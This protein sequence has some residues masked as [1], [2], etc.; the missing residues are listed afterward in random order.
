MHRELDGRAVS[1]VFAFALFCSQLCRAGEPKFYDLNGLPE[2]VVTGVAWW[3]G[4]PPPQTS[5]TWK[6][7][8]DRKEQV[9]GTKPN[10]PIDCNNRTPQ[11]D[12]EHRLSD[13]ENLLNKYKVWLDGKN[14]YENELVLQ[15]RSDYDSAVQN[16]D[17][18]AETNASDA[19][20]RAEQSRDNIRQGKEETDRRFQALEKKREEQ[21][22]E[23]QRACG[24]KPPDKRPNDPNKQPPCKQG[25]GWLCM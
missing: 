1:I 13:M 6:G 11:G 21:E 20:K 19:L 9:D 4:D 23:I 17:T 25:Q 5:G 10:G 16:G 15:Y 2:C 14:Q 7:G 18:K 12:W 3:S 22:D 8:Q 24:D